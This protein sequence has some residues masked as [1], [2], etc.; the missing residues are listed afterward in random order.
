[1]KSWTLCQKEKR[2]A[3]QKTDD[4]KNGRHMKGWTLCQKKK[5]TAT[6]HATRHQ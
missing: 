5:N 3:R 2:P 4:V 1:M 6:N